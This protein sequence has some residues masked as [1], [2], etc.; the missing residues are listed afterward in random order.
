MRGVRRGNP[1]LWSR[2]FFAELQE[3]TGDTGAK[4]VIG[5]WPEYVVE[6]EAEDDGVLIDLDT[7]AALAA[8]QAGT[9]SNV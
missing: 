1:V 4:N 7:P 9:A 6:I 5:A 3:I 8:W 2:R